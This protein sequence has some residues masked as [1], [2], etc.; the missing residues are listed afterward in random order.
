[1]TKSWFEKIEKR[2]KY[3]RKKKE[4]TNQS[5]TREKDNGRE[6]DEQRQQS[7]KREFENWKKDE[8]KYCMYLLPNYVAVHNWQIV[9]D[10]YC[11][12]N[13]FAS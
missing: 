12:W 2:D 10:D 9:R 7:A 11:E 13:K 1:M 8:T 3:E 6:N 4:S 5:W